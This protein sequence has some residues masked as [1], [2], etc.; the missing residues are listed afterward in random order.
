MPCRGWV[1]V[2]AVCLLQG[3]ALMT[4]ETL[5]GAFSFCAFPKVLSS[6]VFGLPKAVS[7]CS[8]IVHSVTAVNPTAVDRSLGASILLPFSYRY[9][10]IAISKCFCLFVWAFVLVCFSLVG[11]FAEVEAVS[12]SWFLCT[13]LCRGQ[14]WAENQSWKSWVTD[15]GIL[16][17]EVD[18]PGIT[19]N[20]GHLKKCL[21]LL[22]IDKIH[23]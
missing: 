9:P 8:R 7:L 20:P 23:W 12:F 10:E 3:M 13:L 5:C 2:A 14:L 16:A 19:W 4:E 18:V 1:R 11:F 15:A 21:R 17:G 6:S 22:S